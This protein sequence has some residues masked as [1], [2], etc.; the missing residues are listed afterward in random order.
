MPGFRDTLASTS[1][2]EGRPLKLPILLDQLPPEVVDEINDAMLL[3]NV[4]LPTRHLTRALN[5]EFAKRD[6]FGTVVDDTV[7]KYREALRKQRGKLQ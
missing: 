4:E 3:S 1:K 2:K 6:I 5:E 7:R